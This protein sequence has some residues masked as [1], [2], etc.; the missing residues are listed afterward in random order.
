[1]CRGPGQCGADIVGAMRRTWPTSRD[2]RR[3]A[4]AAPWVQACW[5]WAAVLGG[6]ASTPA[7]A[8]DA[9][10]AGGGEGLAGWCWWVRPVVGKESVSLSVAR[11]DLSGGSAGGASASGDGASEPGAEPEAAVM[12]TL[13]TV[14]GRVR[15]WAV[16]A[17]AD[18]RTLW[19]VFDDGA[20]AGWTVRDGGPR[21]LGLS[22]RVAPRLPSR[23]KVRSVC[24]IDGRPWVL[25]RAESTDAA[26]EAIGASRSASRTSTDDVTRDLLLLKIP[27]GTSRDELEAD[28]QT[29]VTDTDLTEA[30]ESEQAETTIDAGH[31]SHADEPGTDGDSP[32]ATPPLDA[33]LWARDRADGVVDVLW[34]LDRGRWRAVALPADWPDGEPAWVLQPG[35]VGSAPSL[36]AQQDP[37]LTVW[38]EVSIPVSKPDTEASARVVETQTEQAAR[39]NT[40][41]ADYQTANIEPE[42]KPEPDAEPERVLAWSAM[43]GHIPDGVAGVRVVGVAGQ[44][45]VMRPP[46]PGAQRDVWALR[47]PASPSGEPVTPL[48]VGTLER[49]GDPTR[50]DLMEAVTAMGQALV[51]FAV[52]R[53]DDPADDADV[54][55]AD[56]GAFTAIDLTGRVLTRDHPLTLRSNRANPLAPGRTVMMAVL[57]VSTLVMLVFWRRDP[58]GQLFKLPE[59]AVPAALDRRAIAGAIDLSVGLAVVYAW[60]EMT[61]SELFARWPGRGDE[62]DWA[63]M[64]PGAWCIG[65]TVGHTLVGETI[66]GRSLGK[67]LTG[68]WVVD[69]AGR[70]AR[71]WRPALRCLLKTLDLVAYLLLVLVVVS[72]LRQRLGDLVAGTAVVMRKPSDDVDEDAD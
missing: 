30:I 49:P 16:A 64:V 11:L 58:A 5:L 17:S 67:A 3:F 12:Q 47:A 34:Q 52:P 59:D 50:G 37:A 40:P 27:V 4:S 35:P 71:G 72:P 1:M 48:H 22:P 38:R 10:I 7:M 23:G 66:F 46:A 56:A 60:F 43:S 19:A 18:G 9:A 53:P 68:L 26:L 29:E 63:G 21:G 6:I 8:N 2:A 51:W 39:D 42:P 24:V 44:V 65:V 55:P 57:M 69:A 20:V 62:M 54:D 36:V 15:P 14:P 28:E 25:W 61:P 70:P 45:L 33:A 41:D 32:D 31:D 13:V